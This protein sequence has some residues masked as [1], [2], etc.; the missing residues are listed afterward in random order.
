M[1]FIKLLDSQIIS[2]ISAGEM[3]ERPSSVVKELIENSLDAKST[4]IEINIYHGGSKM[5]IVRDNG[6][7]IHKKEL[8]IAIERFTTSKIYTLKDL[9]SIS[10]FGFRGEALSSIS[11]VSR[12]TLT[13][14]VHNEDLAWQIYAEESKIKFIK[15]VAHP[16][17][18][19]LVV[20]D[21]FYNSPVRKKFMRTSKTEL[22]NVKNIIKQ[23]ALSHKSLSITLYNDG[24]IIQKYP[25]IK[26]IDRLR[27]ICGDSFLTNSIVVKH[28]YKK[29]KLNGLISNPNNY[30]KKNNQYFYVNNRIVNNKI[31]RHAI[32]Q[33]YYDS[34][35]FFTQFK[36]SY[37]LYL[38]IDFDQVDVNHHP[39]KK[40]V[41]F[42][43]VR[44]IH[45][46]IYQG[47]FNKLKKD[48]II[49][50]TLNLNDYSYIE[51]NKI[52]VGLNKFS[53]NKNSMHIHCNKCFI[54][55][56]F[57]K[58]LGKLLTVIKNY[59]VFEKNNFFYIVSINF[60]KKILEKKII[61]YS[62]K[63]LKKSLILNDL[64][65]F[66]NIEYKICFDK[67][68]IIKKIGIKCKIIKNEIIIYAVP[69]F[70]SKKSD[71]LYEFIKFLS[72]SKDYRL[73]RIISWIA[74]FLVDKKKYINYTETIDFFKTI[75]KNYP[76]TIIS[77]NKNFIKIIDFNNIIKI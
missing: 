66:N 30:L 47:I 11:S 51:R 4:N 56:F 69:E 18:T 15:P 8:S 68:K 41:R 50:K 75:E 26:K 10:S 38:I 7:G 49:S 19:T 63:K 12:L 25:I 1:T 61:M 52:P 39:S 35:N 62:I 45:D 60:A 57:S 37:L 23:F 71:I 13:S 20:S 16:F 24:K 54:H 67:L 28:Q 36:P 22:I 32:M 14:R 42:Y 9:I 29:I 21:L 65:K 72:K 55:Q 31:V 53:D 43:N 27:Y 73:N 59:A 17:G 6:Y 77:S 3:I 76:N 74:D 44:I 48:K 58:K 46:F 33:A 34:N 70:F 40:D 2:Q 5:I 64:I